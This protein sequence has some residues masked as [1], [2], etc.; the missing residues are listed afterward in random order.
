M[1]ITD[2]VAD[3]LTKIRNASRARH[4]AVE[5][6]ASRLTQQVLSV[7]KQEGFIRNYKTAGQAPKQTFRVY[8]KYVPPDRTPTISELI[9]VS[10]P[11]LRSYR[12]PQELPKLLG[13]LG[14]AVL[15]TSKGV[16][17]DQEARR[18][19]VGGEVLCYVW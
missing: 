6:R 14:R 8:L 3:F 1:S 11:G 17:T 19:G 2:P 12:G 9:R 4:E 15:T 5:V 18:Q 10:K 13:G 7:L 16:M